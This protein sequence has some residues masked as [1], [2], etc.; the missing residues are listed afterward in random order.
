M[1]LYHG[2]RGTA[3]ETIY[4]DK[5]ESFNINYTSDNNYLGKGTYFAELPAYSH[6]YSYAIKRDPLDLGMMAVFRK[7]NSAKHAMFYCSV[8]V[9]ES[10]NVAQVTAVSSSMRDTDFKNK[11]KR[12]RF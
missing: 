3:P 11:E 8:L 7:D 12:L 5:E 1:M 6:N 9:G 2:T 4:E 10:Q